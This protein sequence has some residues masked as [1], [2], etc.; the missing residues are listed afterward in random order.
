VKRLARIAAIAAA[1]TLAVPAAA[2]SQST[3][4]NCSTQT[5]STSCTVTETGGT[6][7]GQGINS[8]T[9]MVSALEFKLASGTIDDAVGS[10]EL[11]LP[12]RGNTVSG[13]G[14]KQA[15][16]PCPRVKNSK[17]LKVVR[18][19]FV[20]DT[21]YP[22]LHKFQVG[23]QSKAKA[24]ARSFPDG[25]SMQAGIVTPA[26]TLTVTGPTMVP[27]GYCPDSPSCPQGD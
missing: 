17:L 7:S 15:Y 22:T 27:P 8:R 3:I 1:A 9:V 16:G 4:G 24:P 10:F 2:D 26:F 12:G 18:C 20:G 14:I 19:G 6:E 11:S 21:E 5:P 25:F 23:Y 13:A